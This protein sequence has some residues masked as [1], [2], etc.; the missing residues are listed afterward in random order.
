MGISGLTLAYSV[1]SCLLMQT[2]G[3]LCPREDWWARET[4]VLPPHPG[5]TPYGAWQTPPHVTGRVHKGQTLAATE[6]ALDSILYLAAW[7]H[8]LTVQ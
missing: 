2:G 3:S 7:N 8:I 4:R 6:L 5:Q 1:P